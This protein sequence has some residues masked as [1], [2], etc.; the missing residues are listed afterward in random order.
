MEAR[1]NTYDCP[2][3]GGP[4]GEICCELASETN[5]SKRRR[6]ARERAAARR[7]A[8]A[9]LGMVRGR[10]ALGREIWE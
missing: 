5:E 2:T 3:H 10:T 8:Y 4:R 1:P 7:D 6:A 9:S